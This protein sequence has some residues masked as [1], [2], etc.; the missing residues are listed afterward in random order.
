MCEKQN[1]LVRTVAYVALNIDQTSFIFSFFIFV[2][3][4]IV[5]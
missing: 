1:N 4:E 3:L 5:I 2:V